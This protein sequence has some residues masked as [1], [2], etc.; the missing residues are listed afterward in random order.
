MFPRGSNL[1][2]MGWLIDPELRGR[3]RAGKGS[4]EHRFCGFHNKL[5]HIHLIAASEKGGDFPL[6]TEGWGQRSSGKAGS[7]PLAERAVEPHR[8]SK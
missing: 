1:G 4:A 8:G 7:R 5:H 6:G 2:G 3:V